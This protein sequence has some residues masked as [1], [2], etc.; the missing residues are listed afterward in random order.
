VSP[1]SGCRIDRVGTGLSPLLVKCACPS[2]DVFVEHL[3]SSRREHSTLRPLI[4][5][6]VATVEGVTQADFWAAV[7]ASPE[8]H[9]EAPFAV[10]ETVDGLPQV[11]TGVIDLVYRTDAAWQIVDYKTD[12]DAKSDDLSAKY[13][14][15]MKSDEGAWCTVTGA[16][17]DAR[18]VAIRREGP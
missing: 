16:K 9:E 7:R 8:A 13:A 5:E 17:T 6:S 11:L 12:V 18:L 15:Q 10:R 1:M 3:S 4:D 2:M 14:V